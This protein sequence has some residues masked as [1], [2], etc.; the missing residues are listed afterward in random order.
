M[1]YFFTIVGILIA[2]NFYML[3]RR[4]KK[5]RNFKKDSAARRAAVTK[6]HD[7]LVH[8]LDFEQKEAARRV[9]LRNKTLEMYEQVRKR[10]EADELNK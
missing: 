9:Y 1:H 6:N 7:Y 8:K 2:G 5:N 3:F 4:S 10:A